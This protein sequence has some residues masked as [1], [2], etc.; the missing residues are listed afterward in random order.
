MLDTC[1]IYVVK[2]PYEKPIPL[3]N[4]GKNTNIIL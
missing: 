1:S 3:D 4:K 2:A